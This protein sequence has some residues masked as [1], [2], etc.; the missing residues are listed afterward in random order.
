MS[1]KIHICDIASESVKCP[2]YHSHGR[3]YPALQLSKW[4]RKKNESWKITTASEL[5]VL[6]ILFQFVLLEILFWYDDENNTKKKC[7][8]WSVQGIWGGSFY[9]HWLWIEE[10]KKDK[11]FSCHESV[12][13]QFPK[14]RRKLHDYLCLEQYGCSCSFSFSRSKSYFNCEKMSKLIKHNISSLVTSKFNVILFKISAV[15]LCTKKL[16]YVKILV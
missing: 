5:A 14:M 3:V 2:F 7:S 1:H 15:Q 12:Q 10:E 9:W 13:L 8:I 6:S 11:M 16:Q 4:V